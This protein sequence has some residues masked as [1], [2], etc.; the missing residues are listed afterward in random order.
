MATWKTARTGETEA[1]FRQFLAY[2]Y[3]QGSTGKAATG[4]VTG[5]GVT[6][7]TPS[8]T[9]SVVVGIGLAVCQPTTSGG[10]FPM[11][12]GA[13]TTLDIFTANPMQF[14]T[15]PRNDI[16]GVDQSTGA[17]SVLTGTPNAVATDPA[18][19]ATFVPLARLRHAANATTIASSKIDDLRVT[20]KPF[21]ITT[22]PVWTA[23]TPTWTADTTNPSK[24][25][26]TLTGSYLRTGNEIDCVILLTVGS[27]A[28]GG[29]GSYKLS[30]PFT[31]DP[32][33]DIQGR[34][35]FTVGS[36]TYNMLPTFAGGN[37]DLRLLTTANPTGVWDNATPT[38]MTFSTLRLRVRYT[39]V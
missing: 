3:E 13:D 17:L 21:G 5:M 11:P 30:L 8:A 14:V 23:Y 28:V 16:V 15:N 7:T 27:G 22:A 34:A 24:G 10:A 39:A 1:E 29:S 12:N 33:R 37:A 9:G 19:P 20:V 18:I 35:T 2:L 32:N 4:V 36:N 38:A 26:G 25:A 6:A 31:A